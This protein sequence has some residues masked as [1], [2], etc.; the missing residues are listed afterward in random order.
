MQLIGNEQ[1]GEERFKEEKDLNST[2]E[3][4]D[5]DEMLEEK[6]IWIC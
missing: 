6:G 4:E 3:N 5:K 1:V 2:K